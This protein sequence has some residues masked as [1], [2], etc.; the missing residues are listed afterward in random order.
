MELLLQFLRI[1][2]VLLVTDTVLHAGPEIHGQGTELHFHRIV[3]HGV[4]GMKW[5]PENDVIAAV[6]V[7]LG[8]FDVILFLDND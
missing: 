8:I 2:S 1:A 5:H 7:V 4:H 6:A 3:L